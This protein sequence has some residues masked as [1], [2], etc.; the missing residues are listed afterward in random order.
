MFKIMKALEDKT[1]VSI[2]EQRMGFLFVKE[3]EGHGEKEGK[4]KIGAALNTFL[5][6]P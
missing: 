3:L 1:T 6:S 5:L 2:S 4:Q